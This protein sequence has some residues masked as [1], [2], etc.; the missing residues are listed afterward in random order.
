MPIRRPPTTFSDEINAADLAAN[1]VGAS[2][3]ADNAVDTAAIADDAVTNAKV[4]ASAI[5]AT[6]LA[7]NAVTTAKITDANITAAKVAS[8]AI[9]KE[10]LAAEAI[11]VK[12][13]IKYGMLYPALKD[14]GGTVRL[15]DGVTAHSGTVYGTA[16]ADGKSYYYTDIKGSK[17]IKD[18]RIGGHFGSQ[19]H[20][21]KSIQLLEQETTTHGDKVYSI[22]GREWMRCTGA[23][24]FVNATGGVY[25]KLASATTSFFEITGYFNGFN[26]LNL[27]QDS[28]R[29]FKVEVD[30]VTAHASFNP[31]GAV[32]SPLALRYTSSGSVSNV[33]IT[34]SSSLSSDTALG[35]HTIRL[36]Y[37]SGSANY[38]TGCELITQDTGSTARKQHV[39]IPA[40]NVVSYGKKFSV[41]SATLTNAVHKH[42][43]P[44]AFKTDGTTAW[45]SGTNNGTSFPV[46]TGSSHNIDTATS[47]GLENWKSGTDYYKPY[48]GGRV[49]RWVANDGTIKTSVTVMPPN[50][51]S[52]GNSAS[53][54]NGTAKANASIANNTYYPTFEAGTTDDF[55]TTALTEIAKE[56]H[57]RE[58]GNGSCNAGSNSAN[59][60][61]PSMVSGTADDC[62]WIMDDGLT[63][64]SWDN[65]LW[66]NGTGNSLGMGVNSNN[67]GW[68]FIFIGTGVTVRT[69]HGNFL[70]LAQNLP[71]GTHIVK[72]VYTGSPNGG[73]YTID[74]V[75]V[76]NSNSSSVYWTQEWMGFYQPK[77]PPVPDDACILADYMLM[78][79]FVKQTATSA[80][81]YGE[82][83]KGSRLVSSSRDHFYNSSAAFHAE[84]CK[85]RGDVI[86]LPVKNGSAD[87]TAKLP[88]FGTTGAFHV[89]YSEQAWPCELGGS[90]AT[91]T[92]LDN[93]TSTLGDAITIAETVTLGQTSIQT[94]I[95]S[96][97]Y[98]I[99][100]TQVATP[101]HTSSHYQPF[102]TPLLKELVGGDRNMEQ[103][104]LIVTPDGKSWEEVTRDTSYIGSGRVSAAAENDTWILN[105]DNGVFDE[106]R[107]ADS[108]AVGP[109]RY[110]KDFA[111]GHDRFICLVDGNYKITFKFLQKHAE[112]VYLRVNGANISGSHHQANSGEYGTA[113]MVENVQ[114][115]RGDYVHTYDQFHGGIWSHFYI[116]RI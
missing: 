65:C 116:E 55:P 53:L 31:N 18:P 1:S 39:N 97:E 8:S 112:H 40:Q 86:G 37:V 67:D 22:D 109:A 73:T 111:I 48:N 29:P 15:S 95:P 85:P 58:F 36:S 60:A 28:S 69:P 24:D 82:I 21:F 27:T 68:Y 34:A 88:F 89:A 100:S 14:T 44:F 26:F 72:L 77:K 101:I 3:L 38:P 106:M 30:G 56:F 80:N 13:H 11:E 59:F 52:I 6:E 102:E 76:T 83:S 43:N 74:G 54:T 25:V 81:I 7:S 115:K 63:S 114:L 12:P 46:G 107:G 35:I 49:V 4:G 78:A 79:D 104:N 84:S 99:V 98:I 9:T 10:K 47:L 19:R 50:A 51:R 62:A 92:K 66:Y 2:E 41:G 75:P 103:N 113:I 20:M 17:P 96:G 94:T 93:T 57:W 70:Q 90:A 42:Y 71:Y 23:I 105:N 33:D 110:N 91:E 108:T 45:A 32:N 5:G 16:Q 87:A 61:D 64:L